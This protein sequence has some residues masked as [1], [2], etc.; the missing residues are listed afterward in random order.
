[1]NLITK[2]KHLPIH[3]IGTIRESLMAYVA[4]PWRRWSIFRLFIIIL[5]ARNDYETI[6]RAIYLLYNTTYTYMGYIFM[7]KV[8]KRRVYALVYNVSCFDIVLCTH[9]RMRDCLTKRGP[10][11]VINVSRTHFAHYLYVF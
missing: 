7:Y 10:Q 2:K 9:A 5:S 8:Y 6:A 11:I 4:V 1:M 3:R